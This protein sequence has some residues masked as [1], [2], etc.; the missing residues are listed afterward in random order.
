MEAEDF[1]IYRCG[2]LTNNIEF[3]GENEDTEHPNRTY[4][5]CLSSKKNLRTITAAKVRLMSNISFITLT[6]LALLLRPPGTGLAS[7]RRLSSFE[8]C[9]SGEYYEDY[10]LKGA[11]KA[12]NYTSLGMVETFDDCVDLCCE[13]KHCT[14]A[15]MLRHSC[16][17]VDCL[18]GNPH[19]CERI[20]ARRS[21][22]NPKLFIRGGV[23]KPMK[24]KYIFGEGL[25]VLFGETLAC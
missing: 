22:Y 12:G 15:L 17:R 13:D 24:S 1:G 11:K 6:I 25:G 21:K 14:M 2:K 23:D 3:Y 19:R 8:L 16:F 18:K 5:T 7:G 9:R 10:A 20:S 4:C